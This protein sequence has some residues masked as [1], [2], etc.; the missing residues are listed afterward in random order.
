MKIKDKPCFLVGC[1]FL[2]VIGFELTK[3]GMSP[4]ITRDPLH[5]PTMFL[6]TT[7]CLVRGLVGAP[8]AGSTSF[9]VLDLLKTLVVLTVVIIATL[10]LLMH[11]NSAGPLHW[12]L[13]VITWIILIPALFSSGK[14]SQPAPGH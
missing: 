1:L 2:G 13:A 12:L 4:S 10:A 6:V 3:F 14:S 7:Y 5:W 8:A 9:K 11:P